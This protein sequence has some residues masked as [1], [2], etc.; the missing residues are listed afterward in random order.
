MASV[1]RYDA[2]EKTMVPAPGAG[3][4]SD[5]PDVTEGLCAMAW[6]SNI[7]SDTMG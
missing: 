6:A 3:G 1:Y 2:G 5:A 7:L 4:L